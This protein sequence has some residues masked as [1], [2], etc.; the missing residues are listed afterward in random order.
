MAPFRFDV[1]AILERGYCSPTQCVFCRLRYSLRDKS[2]TAAFGANAPDPVAVTEG[3]K[4]LRCPWEPPTPE[5]SKHL[6]AIR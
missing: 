4:L 1:L 3:H 2:R 5:R 6:K